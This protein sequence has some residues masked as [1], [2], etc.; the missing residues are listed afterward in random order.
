M[1]NKNRIM[2]FNLWYKLVRSKKTCQ[3]IFMVPLFCNI[4]IG[5]YNKQQ[6]NMSTFI[7]DMTAKPS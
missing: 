1:S 7:I 5:P 3:C 6:P 2:N 4:E